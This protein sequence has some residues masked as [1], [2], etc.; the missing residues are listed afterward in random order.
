[1]WQ[2]AW[3][4]KLESMHS[5]AQCGLQLRPV[6]EPSYRR[7]VGGA[8]AG[9]GHLPPTPLAQLRQLPHRMADTAA[10]RAQTCPASGVAG[11]DMQPLDPN[12]M[13]S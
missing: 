10:Q 1:M 3:Q 8:G 13:Q 12:N 2:Q 5:R 7:L 6:G 9:I 4:A 11:Q